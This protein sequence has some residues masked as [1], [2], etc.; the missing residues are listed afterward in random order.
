MF[1]YFRHQP[2]STVP[3]VAKAVADVRTLDETAREFMQR[4]GR[5][6][7]VASAQQEAARTEGRDHSHELHEHVTRQVITII[8]MADKL[9]ERA[10]DALESPY[11]HTMTDADRGYVTDRR[12]EIDTW[13]QDETNRVC[14]ELKKIIPA[15][16]QAGLW[17]TDPEHADG[18]SLQP[19][20]LL[21]RKAQLQIA[22]LLRLPH[23]RK[24]L[25]DERI[26]YL[27]DAQTRHAEAA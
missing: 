18:T 15:L 7:A 20:R 6:F 16:E 4:A 1:E 11:A 12:E 13:L 27:E 25:D 17:Q 24:H 26:D 5:D 10:G 8:R 2:A 22:C 9:L 3:S 19:E 23:M 21:V 14:D